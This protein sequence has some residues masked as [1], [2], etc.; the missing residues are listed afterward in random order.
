MSESRDMSESRV[1]PIHDFGALPLVKVLDAISS[2][3]PSSGAGA[4]AAVA[5]ALAVACALKAV[6]VTLKHRA[7]A[8]LIAARERLVQH[9]E[10]ALDRARVDAELFERYLA[11]HEPRDVR[12]SSS[13][14]KTSMRYR[15]RSDRRSSRWAM[16]YSTP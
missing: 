12:V 11:S 4:A 1:A 7:D 9:R 6:N 5:L 3:E 13:Q 14:A 10:L 2:A 15:A 8:K 16:P